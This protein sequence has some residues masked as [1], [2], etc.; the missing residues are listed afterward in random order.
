M[1]SC[2]SFHAGAG[3]QGE[4]EKR[5]VCKPENAGV[6]GRGGPGRRSSACAPPSPESQWP[7]RPGRQRRRRCGGDSKCGP[8]VGRGSGS[9]PAIQAPGRRLG[10]RACR[11]PLMGLPKDF[12]RGPQDPSTATSCWV[13]PS[14]SPRQSSLF[15]LPALFPLLPLFSH[16][17]SVWVSI[18]FLPQILFPLPCRFPETGPHRLDVVLGVDR[19]TQSI[20]KAADSRPKLGSLKLGVG[21]HNAKADSVM[22]SGWRPVFRSNAFPNVSFTSPLTPFHRFGNQGTEGSLIQPET[23]TSSEPAPS[24]RRCLHWPQ[25][26]QVSALRRGHPLS[27]VTQKR[28]RIELAQLLWMLEMLTRLNP[29]CAGYPGA[30]PFLPFSFFQSESQQLAFIKSNETAHS[31]ALACDLG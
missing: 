18:V 3:A 8:E 1:G 15:F 4:D 27:Q 23:E 14:V 28:S 20:Q 29:A 11:P 10:S 17:P 5:R 24:S 30:L 22:A 12:S 9:R 21:V 2:G 6:G 26:P 19:S 31:S 7:G 16:F 13:P 25:A